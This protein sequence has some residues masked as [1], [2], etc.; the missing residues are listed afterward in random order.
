[1]TA[2]TTTMDPQVFDAWVSWLRAPTKQQCFGALARSSAGNLTRS[3]ALAEMVCAIG[4]GCL[5]MRE[6]PK[7]SS[8][9]NQLLPPDLANKVVAWNDAECLSFAQIADRLE[10]NRDLYVRHAEP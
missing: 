7:P 2:A 6:D 3:A 9:F 4:A 10:E 8:S 5:A 1:M